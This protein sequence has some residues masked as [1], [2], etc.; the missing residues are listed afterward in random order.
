[1]FEILYFSAASATAAAV[2]ALCIFNE[3][4][5]YFKLMLL[6]LLL[7]P[8]VAYVKGVILEFPPNKI[9]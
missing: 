6:W 1:M 2:L 7:P 5:L 3:H 4:N 8:V 9:N